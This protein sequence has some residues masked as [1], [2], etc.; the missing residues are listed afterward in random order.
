MAQNMEQSTTYRIGHDHKISKVEIIEGGAAI[1]IY[2]EITKSPILWS[3]EEKFFP[4]VRA[5]ELSLKDKI[6]QHKPNTDR[7]MEFRDRLVSVIE[8]GIPDF[9]AQSCHPLFDGKKRCLYYNRGQYFWP[10]A[11]SNIKWK[12]VAEEFCPSKKSRLG[13]EKERNAFLGVIIK[14]LVEE[15]H[16]SLENA[17]YAV[18]DNSEEI[19]RYRLNDKKYNS[20]GGFQDLGNG[21]SITLSD[22]E[23]GVFI[24]FGG[25]PDDRG[26]Y[27]PLINTIRD[28]TRAD[29]VC[30]IAT[31]WVV[32][33]V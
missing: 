12:I 22:K 1:K 21:Y 24:Y 27:R 11:M 30:D 6:F 13:Y 16:Y 28:T 32:T 33:E 31:G 29:Y 15:R 18:C 20:I 7:Q 9:R 26:D 3:E 17:W 23:D 14:L 2:Y 10:A 19:A 5:S 4:I 8:S 25:K